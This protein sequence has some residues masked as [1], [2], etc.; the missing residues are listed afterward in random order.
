MN[1][2]DRSSTREKWTVMKYMHDFNLMT[3][4]AYA[5]RSANVLTDSNIKD[6]LR[7]MERQGTYHPR[8]G[9]VSIDTGKFKIIQIAWYMFAYYGRG[10]EA[11]SMSNR[12][13]FTP[14]GNLLL[15]N[16]GDREKVAKIFLAMLF[17]NPFRQP[18]SRMGREFNIFAFRLFFKLLRD[19]RLG[20]R[21]YNDEMFY[22]TMFMKSVNSFSYE[23]LVK[24]ILKL[25]KM[26]SQAK[27]RLFLRNESV[28]AQTLHEW[29]YASGL[30]ESA[31]IL[32]I[33]KVNDGEAVG[34]LTH[35]KGTGRRTYR[36]EYVEA[37]PDVISL[38]DKLLA[39]YPYDEKPYTAE[40]QISSFST[41]MIVH[42]YT[43][44]PAELLEEIG[45]DQT[46]RADIIASLQVATDVNKFSKDEV[47]NRDCY[48]FEEALCKAFNLFADVKAERIGGAGATDIECIYYPPRTREYKFDV[49]AKARR[50][51][52]MQISE[53][54]LKE[55]RLQIGSRYTMVVTSDFANAVLHDI[56]GG[57]SA[58]IK[59]ATLSNFF[60]Q[61][62]AK[63][64]RD[65]SYAPLE[66]IM[67]EHL[68]ED[69]TD[70][71]NEYV[72]ANF[73]HGF[74]SAA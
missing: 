47:R 62:I 5:L 40:E 34:V 53:G 63:Y 15:D 59:A 21:V 2:Y 12:F 8:Y 60:Y 74:G 39:A 72:Y 20:G 52:L 28:V 6:V 42:K 14:L 37:N 48:L 30:M 17:G 41:E 25:R 57:Q 1:H 71:V 16:L 61:Y 70:A 69:I 64:G 31:G 22:Y 18:F 50:V 3:T 19:R 51:K 38:M 68:G 56:T 11:Q 4:Y 7:S 24:D 65:L 54:R 67:T 32:K 13:V 33:E 46:D 73:G 29:T 58:I 43:F 10:S 44:Y 35:G 23:D 9:K 36:V 26:T 66:K 45:V 55:H 49:E 27:Y